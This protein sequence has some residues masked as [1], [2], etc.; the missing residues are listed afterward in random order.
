MAL[1]FDL[2][3]ISAAEQCPSPCRQTRFFGWLITIPWIS[4]R[5]YVFKLIYFI[6]Q[7]VHEASAEWNGRKLTKSFATSV[8]LTSLIS[9]LNLMVF[10]LLSMEQSTSVP[11]CTLSITNLGMRS[12]D[13]FDRL[14][15]PSDEALFEVAVDVPGDAW[16]WSAC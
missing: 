9:N 15:L 6:K 4:I 11:F 14:D 5:N 2:D 10:N 7:I 1:V 13:L 16:S 8:G 3:S 12:D